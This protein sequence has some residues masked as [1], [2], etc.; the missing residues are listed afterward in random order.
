MSRTIDANLCPYGAIEMREDNGKVTAHIIEAL[1]KGCGVCGAA[2][3][4]KAITLGHFTDEE[5]IAQV[6][7]AL[8]EEAVI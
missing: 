7:A 5:I 8:E 1:C 6:R 2:C 3:P 4:M